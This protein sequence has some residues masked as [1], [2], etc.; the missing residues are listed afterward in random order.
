MLCHVVKKFDA[1]SMY[2][3]YV[4]WDTCHKISTTRKGTLETVVK[5]TAQ[6]C[7]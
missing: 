6:P 4:K 1:D 7:L 3:Y 2:D 5:D